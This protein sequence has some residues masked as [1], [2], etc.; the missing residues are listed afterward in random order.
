[1]NTTARRV[2][3]IERKIAENE[4]PESM[5][6]VCTF[7]CPER[8]LVSAK[9][10]GIVLERREAETEE[11]FKQRVQEFTEMEENL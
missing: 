1:M 11:A 3:S 8:G 4:P 2:K 7:V 10:Q 5:K 9:F 6:I